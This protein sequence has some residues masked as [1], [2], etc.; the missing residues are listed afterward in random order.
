[1]TINA[2]LLE[3]IIREAGAIALAYFDDLKNLE[4]SK[5]SS[6]DLVTEADVAVEAFLKDKLA[7]EFPQ[8]GFWGEESG[9]TDNQSNRWIVDP[10]IIKGF[11]LINKFHIL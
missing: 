9:K 11:L 4:I 7:E 10:I 2:E 5:K 6:R 3:K 1:M 8:Y